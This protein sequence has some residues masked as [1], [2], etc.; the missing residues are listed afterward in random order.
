MN[1]PLMQAVLDT[2][3][4]APDTETFGQARRQWFTKSAAFDAM[5]ASQFS[6]AI[7]RAVL[8]ELASWSATPLG[9]LAL[10]VL[11]DQFSRNIFRGSPKAFTGDRMALSLAKSLVASAAD[12]TLPTVF[13]RVFVYMPFEHDE[14]LES[15]RESVQRFMQ[16]SL[17]TDDP[18]IHD[19]LA[20][21]RR[22]AGVIERFGRF[23]HRNAIL[24]RQTTPA[25]SEWLKRHGG[26]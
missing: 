3:F 18:A 9:T 25:E 2:W 6:R 15:Q 7:D 19:N 5:L 4:G 13:H 20:Y 1:D 8:G 16:L 14:S 17:E 12:R 24:G 22:H 11:L 23:P 26:F 21:A 10:I